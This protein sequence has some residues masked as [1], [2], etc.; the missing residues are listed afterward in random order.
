MTGTESFGDRLRRFRLRAGMSRPVLAGL[1]GRSPEWVKAVET[2]RLSMPRLEM[3]VRLAEALGIRDL[4]ELTGDSSV[5]IDHLRRGQLAP[6]PDIRAAVLRYNITVPDKPPY[7]T[8][9]LAARASA[10]WALWHTSPQR[11]E[12]V[13]ALLPALLVDCQDAAASLTGDAQRSAYRVLVDVYHLTQH[14]LVNAAEPQLLWVVVDRAMT[15]AQMADDPLTIAGAAWTVGMMQR[16]SGQMD[17]ALHLV[18]E[19]S[20]HL[21]PVLA[22]AGDEARAMWGALQLHAAITLART[23][24][25]GEAWAAWDRAQ[26]A[27]LRLP[28]QYFHPWT[29][30]GAANVDLHGISLTVDL[31]KSRDALRRA[32]NVDPDQLP[33]R[34]RRGRLFVE[35]ARGYY[36]NNDR[37]SATRMLLRACD[38]GTDAVM[39]SPAARL[40]VDDLTARPPTVVRADVTALA[41]KLGVSLS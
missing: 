16:G 4:A 30:F 23:G 2:S 28:A 32:E 14:V 38:E 40:I 13:G 35:M 11:R 29:I 41:G 17:A 10:A 9:V 5:T 34:E 39:W 20:R 24:R 6:V 25:D 19:A 18:N 12:T 3:L 31:W 22:D 21:E 26:Q 15:A 1:V 27:A 8:A 7:P 36:A 37:V 33:S